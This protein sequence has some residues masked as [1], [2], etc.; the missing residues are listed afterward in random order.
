MLTINLPAVGVAVSL[1]GLIVL[2]LIVGVMSGMFGA[3][4]GFLLTPF[5]RIFFGIPFPLAIGSSLLQI[6]FTCSG[7]SGETLETKDD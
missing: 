4:G 6:F 7:G 5:L 3:G 2:G 1:P